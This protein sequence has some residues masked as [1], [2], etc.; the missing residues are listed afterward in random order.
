MVKELNELREK[1]NEID[2]KTQELFIKRMEIVRDIYKIKKQCN[3]E[4]F[5]KAREDEI[6]KNIVKNPNPIIKNYYLSIQ[7]ELLNVSKEYQIFL[8]N[9]LKE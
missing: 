9:T 1:I 7:K 5:D 2:K 3:M 8:Q 4:I 6:I